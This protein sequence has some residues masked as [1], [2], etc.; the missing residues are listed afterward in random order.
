MTDSSK[1]EQPAA[2][3]PERGH[4][5][6]SANLSFAEAHAE[7]P[8][9]A[10]Q[11]KNEDSPILEPTPKTA[12]EVADRI[13]LD[14]DFVLHSPGDTKEL[15]MLQ[16]DAQAIMVKPEVPRFDNKVTD[17]N[18]KFRADV[19][20]ALQDALKDRASNDSITIDNTGRI[21]A[22]NDDNVV[23]RNGRMMFQTRKLSA[24]AAGPASILDIGNPWVGPEKPSKLAA[25]I[26]KNVNVLLDSWK[27]E[28]NADKKT[29]GADLIKDL[30]LLAPKLKSENG[31]RVDENADYRSAVRDEL[32]KIAAKP[33]FVPLPHVSINERGDL[34]SFTY[35]P[36]NEHAKLLFAHPGDPN[37]PRDPSDEPTVIEIGK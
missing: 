7:T 14:V 23:I 4:N 5:T 18:E 17:A 36:G 3:S 19:R 15:A 13:V 34:E 21:L 31:V 28:P 10:G 25:D 24:D 8:G 26:Q 27:V 33:Q 30:T 9:K 11:A 20:T 29:A 32:A 2:N 37:L 12:K 16:Q 6:N 1:L 22:N 35:T